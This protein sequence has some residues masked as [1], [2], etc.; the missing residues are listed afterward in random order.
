[1]YFSPRI[2]TS[3][4]T[5]CLDTA[6]KNSYGGSGTVWKDL[7]QGLVF[8]STGVTQTPFT[9]IGGVPC[10][11]FNSSGYWQCSSGF[12][13]VDLGGDCTI[14]IWFYS[15]SPSVRRTIFQKAGTTFQ[16]Y[17]QEIAVTWELDSAPNWSYYS[18]QSAAYDYATVAGGSHNKW[19]M[20]TITM[21]TGKTTSA[22]VGVSYING[23]TPATSYYNSRS[24]VALVAAGAIQI[25]TGYAG[26]VDV[27]YI[28]SVCCY[29]RVLSAT[30]VLQNYNA[31]KT[32]FGL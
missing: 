7:A 18:R 20:M 9:K 25:G 29:N 30:E 32:R 3:G 11:A 12:S 21:T 24:S 22:R 6:D 15:Q 5:L 13:Q 2:V 10:F 23:T 19:N 4:L 28:S 31:T 26:T 16:S 27:G 17:E 1:M 8:N 14:S